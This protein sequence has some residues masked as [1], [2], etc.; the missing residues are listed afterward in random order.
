MVFSSSQVRSISNFTKEWVSV[1]AGAIEFIL[2]NRSHP[3]P[4]VFNLLGH[5]E[6]EATFH[7]EYCNCGVLFGDGHYD[8]PKVT[9]EFAS[10]GMALLL[11]TTQTDYK[12]PMRRKSDGPGVDYTLFKVIPTSENYFDEDHVHLECKGTN[13]K[14]YLNRSFNAAKRQ[15]RDFPFFAVAVE[16]EK[17]TIKSMLVNE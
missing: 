6:L 12:L 17:C 4:M 13:T 1:F 11:V 10:T 14:A 15:G 16:F 9:V 2:N 3:N 8:E 7:W 5:W